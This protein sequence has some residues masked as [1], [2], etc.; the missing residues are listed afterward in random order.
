MRWGGE[1]TGPSPVNRQKPGAKHHVLTDGNGIPIVARTTAAI[2]HDVTELLTL[3]NEVP[4]F[5]GKAGSPLYRFEELYADRAYDSDP[6]REALREVGIT[7]CI[8]RRHTEHGSGLG[9]Y[10]WVMERTLSW[11]H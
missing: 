8:D 7:P 9:V 1:K 2:Q 5:K 6:H 3:V 10:R 4:A 11:L